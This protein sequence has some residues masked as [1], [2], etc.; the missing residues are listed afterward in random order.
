MWVWSHRLVWTH[1]KKCVVIKL[2]WAIKLF[3]YR[4]NGTHIFLGGGY[5]PGIHKIKLSHCH[6]QFAKASTGLINNWH[7]LANFTFLPII[8]RKKDI[9]GSCCCVLSP[10]Y[11]LLKYLSEDVGKTIYKYQPCIINGNEKWFI[12]PASAI[13]FRFVNVKEYFSLS[14]I[15]GKRSHHVSH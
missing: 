14:L 3:H 13:R 9:F 7:F 2:I 15:R 8:K 10:K 4:V 5:S 6:W 12:F 1:P 11:H